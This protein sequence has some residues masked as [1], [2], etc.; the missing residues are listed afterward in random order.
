MK[1]ITLSL[2]VIAALAFLCLETKSAEAAHGNRG[3][4][5][6]YGGPF[7]H[8]DIGNPHRYGRRQAHVARR[9]APV[10]RDWHN[11]GHFDY[12]PPRSVPHYNHYDYAPGRVQYHQT[13]HWDSHY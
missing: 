12:V 9:Y 11:T 6:H 2:A 4:G 10:H 8:I 7:F 1:K 5:L 3:A 13:G